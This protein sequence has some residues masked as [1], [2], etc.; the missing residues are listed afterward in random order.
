M[1][2]ADRGHHLHRLHNNLDHGADAQHAPL[3][4]RRRRELRARGGLPALRPPRG[5]LHVLVHLRVP[6]MMIQ[7]VG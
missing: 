1:L 2:V 6:G 3:L 5:R 4:L 7:T